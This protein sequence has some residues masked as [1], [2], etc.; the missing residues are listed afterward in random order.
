M[1]EAR[2]V[3]PSVSARLKACRSRLEFSDARNR[4]VSRDYC[5]RGW[6]QL[7]FGMFP[8]FSIFFFSS[9][10]DI[11]RDFWERCS[12]MRCDAPATRSLCYLQLRSGVVDVDGT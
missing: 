3:I 10:V 7:L 2:Q 9:F 5:L 4:G 1:Q 8:C 11:C 6:L 12:A